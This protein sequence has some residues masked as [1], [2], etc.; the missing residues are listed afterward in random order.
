MAGISKAAAVAAALA[1]LP[2]FGVPDAMARPA[3]ATVTLFSPIDPTSAGGTAT[4]VAT[5]AGNGNGAPTG[6]VQFKDGAG[7]LGA[8]AAINVRGAGHPI[9]AGYVHTCALTSAGGVQCWGANGQG[10]LGDG[11]TTER[12]SPGPVSGLSSGVLELAAGDAH[13][14]AVTVAG[15]VLCWGDNG[16]GQLGDSS[17]IPR[18]TPVAVTGLGS[19]VVAVTAGGSKSCALT[20]AGA[21]MC[22]GYNGDGQLG[23]GTTT[24]RNAPVPVSGLTRGVVGIAAG[25]GHVCALTSAGAVK[26]WG[27]GDYG[28]LGDGGETQQHKPVQTAGLRSGVVAIASGALHSCALTNTSQV[29]CWGANGSGQSGTGLNGFAQR[30]PARVIGLGTTPAGLGLGYYHSCAIL[31]AGTLKCWGANS[32]GQLGDGTNTGRP[33]PVSM[34]GITGVSAV[35][36]HMGHTCAVTDTG[37]A[38]CTGFNGEGEL[39][40]GATAEQHAPVAVNGFGAG[41]AL[42]VGKATYSLGDLTSGTH[43]IRGAYSGDATHKPALSPVVRQR[44][45]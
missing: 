44:V 4:F 9:A 18:K 31:A 37:V 13:T 5:V 43:L 39:G 27:A 15:A 33:A 11:T 8:A 21:V 20:S 6:T 26:C 40:N 10:E 41:A 28:Q 19:G 17:T 7:A 35:G 16:N 14:C 3:A 34:I 29:K 23:D 38:K 2:M 32:N 45:R 1:S 25:G 42:I 24:D 22:W 12:H 30:T 36:A